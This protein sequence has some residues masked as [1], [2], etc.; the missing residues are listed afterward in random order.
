[1][2]E[3]SNPLKLKNDRQIGKAV[4]NAIPGYSGF[5]PGKISESVI[6]ASFRKANVISQHIRQGHEPRDLSDQVNPMGLIAP[7][8]AT[9]PGYKGY[10]PGRYSENV[11]GETFKRANELSSAIK[12]RQYTQ[13]QYIHDQQ[14]AAGEKIFGPRRLQG[15]AGFY[16]LY[17][18]LMRD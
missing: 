17:R 2:D 7:R 11:V 5:V 14:V 18:T 13:A 9:I 8:G 3:S 6:A 16:P 15:N 1:V 4:I 10:I 12:R